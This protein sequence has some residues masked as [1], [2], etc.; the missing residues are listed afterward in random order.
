MGFELLDSSDT[1]DFDPVA[2]L[3]EL[4]KEELQRAITIHGDFLRSAGTQGVTAGGLDR[5]ARGFSS[6]SVLIRLFCN[7]KFVT[8]LDRT[9]RKFKMLGGRWC[10]IEPRITHGRNV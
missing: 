1:Q 3:Y 2:G 8:R 4:G 9:L 7:S 5:L 6:R 10:G